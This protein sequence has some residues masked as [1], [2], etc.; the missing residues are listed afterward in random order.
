[1]PSIYINMFVDELKLKLNMEDLCQYA[2][3]V[4]DNKYALIEGVKNLVFSSEE[5]VKVRVKK[6]MIIL[7]GKELKIK[8]VGDGNVLVSGE[9]L[10]V[11][12]E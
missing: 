4:F 10:G 12:Y 8:E 2:L 6:M 11:K 5:Q 1:M 3:S 7:E 9:I